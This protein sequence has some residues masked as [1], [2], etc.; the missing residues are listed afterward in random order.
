[1]GALGLITPVC[2]GGPQRTHRCGQPFLCVAVCRRHSPLA[3]VGSVCFGVRPLTTG[4]RPLFPAI[5]P[6]IKDEYLH[7][8]E[9]QISYY[10]ESTERCLALNDDRS[11]EDRVLPPC[12]LRVC[13]YPVCCMTQQRLI[14]TWLWLGCGAFSALVL[15]QH[16]R[17]RAHFCG[18][19]VG[20]EQRCPPPPT[21]MPWLALL[22]HA[23][24]LAC[25]AGL[26][27]SSV[28]LCACNR[29]GHA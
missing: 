4:A 1:M 16:C 23:P 11:W 2:P 25:V 6:L 27:V 15:H 18:S 29:V 17:H 28:H 3:R 22:P 5:M 8:V 20:L 13:C 10:V 9:I 19:L 26:C 14:G 12:H 24:E 21:A 7:G